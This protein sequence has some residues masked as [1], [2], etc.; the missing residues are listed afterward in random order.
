MPSRG[1][2]RFRFLSLIQ[3]AIERLSWL[4]YGNDGGNILSRLHDWPSLLLASPRTGD[5]TWPFAGRARTRF[6][7]FHR[8]EAAGGIL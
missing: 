6:S 8:P 7:L 1:G 5:T 2:A 4:V 3:T